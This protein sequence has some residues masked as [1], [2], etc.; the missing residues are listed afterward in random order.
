MFRRKLEEYE[1]LPVGKLLD[2]LKELTEIQR[3]AFESGDLEGQLEAISEKELIL[4]ALFVAVVERFAKDQYE[5][6]ADIQLKSIGMLKRLIDGE[7]EA[8]GQDGDLIPMAVVAL[9]MQF[10]NCEGCNLVA[11]IEKSSF[12]APELSRMLN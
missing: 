2:E 8:I 7:T 11:E 10:N 6:S 9:I 12:P 5:L 1:S 3:E 4:A